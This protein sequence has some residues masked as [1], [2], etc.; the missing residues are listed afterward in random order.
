MLA[1]TGIRWIV[2]SHSSNSLIIQRFM[3]DPLYTLYETTA[4]YYVLSTP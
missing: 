3:D 2:L 4:H 1:S